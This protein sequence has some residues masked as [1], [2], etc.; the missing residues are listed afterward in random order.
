MAEN[1]KTNISHSQTHIN[2]YRLKIYRVLKPTSNGIKSKIQNERSRTLFYAYGDFC[3]DVLILKKSIRQ[4]LCN[5]GAHERSLKSRNT[6]AYVW[7]GLLDNHQTPDFIHL[8]VCLEESIFKL[9]SPWL[10]K[11]KWQYQYEHPSLYLVFSIQW[12]RIVAF[13][14]YFRLNWHRLARQHFQSLKMVINSKFKIPNAR[15]LFKSLKNARSQ[16]KLKTSMQKWCYLYGIGRA[17][18]DFI[19]IPLMNDVSHV[20]WFTY[21]LIT[22]MTC[23]HYVQSHITHIMENCKWSPHHRLALH[24]YL[25]A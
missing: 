24:S 8:V 11:T 18:L 12:R 6:L 5:F 25:S 10:Q 3:S 4:Y 9:L 19:R 23:S 17:A 16:W 1:E 13:S 2:S 21:C 14:K 20:H 15:E 7:F 22:Y